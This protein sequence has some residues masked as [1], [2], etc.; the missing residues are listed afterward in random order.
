MIPFSSIEIDLE[1]NSRTIYDD[2]PELAESIKTRGLITPLTVMQAADGK[3]KLIAGYRRYRALE[4]LKTK[5]N[6]PIKV[7]MEGYETDGD[8]YLA[9]LVENTARDDMHPSD[10]AKRFADLEAGT[11][12][13]IINPT[14]EGEEVTVGE[15]ISRK[16]IAR[17][18]GMSTAHIG[19]L[20]R[21]HENLGPSVTKMWRKHEI[22]MSKIFKWAAIKDEEVQLNEFG[23]WKE[24]Q[25]A[26]KTNGKKKKK[27]AAGANGAAEAGGETESSGGGGGGGV[28]K[29]EMKDQLAKL[30]VK[31]EKL[32]G[33]KG[34]EEKLLIAE[35]KHHT[36]EWVLGDRVRL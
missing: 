15:K 29:S 33:V 30:E 12:R 20:I 2:I 22:P 35:T 8:L 21:V 19:N 36:I 28:S 23:S 1:F 11:Y 5:P 10:L 27:K 3:H 16:E 7:N 6:E 4:L 13:R 17:H 18:T 25:D 34:E 32:K 24:Q 31:I 26:E 9:N 14:A